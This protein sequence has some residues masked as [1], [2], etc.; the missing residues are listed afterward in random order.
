MKPYADTNFLTALFCGGP[1][2][3][4]A[5]TFRDRAERRS[6]LPLP[7]TGIGRMELTNALE[8]R[9][10]MARNGVPG[11]HA[12]PEMALIEEALI[13]E[14][15][16]RSEIICAVSL[17]EADLEERFAELSHRHTAKAGF[18]TYDI[19]HVASALVL[20]CDTFWSFDLKAGKLAAL[21]GMRTQ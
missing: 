3:A 13:L 7:V 20:G 17:L 12:T 11:V 18:R 16:E 6:A 4:E 19:I 8:L 2:G 10:F 9:V 5:A 14:E 21:E 15:F 1:H